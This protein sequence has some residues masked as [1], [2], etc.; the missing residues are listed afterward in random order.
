MFLMITNRFDIFEHC[1]QGTN[2]GSLA[3]T[4]LPVRLET[5]NA[6]W[7]TVSVTGAVSVFC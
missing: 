6:A 5:T 4:I 1:P 7:L 2:T 3:G